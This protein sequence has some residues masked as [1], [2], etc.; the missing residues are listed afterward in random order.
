MPNRIIREALLT[1]PRVAKLKFDNRWLY[2]GLLLSADDHGRIEYTSDKLLN[3]KIFPLDDVRDSD[4]SRWLAECEKAGL[5]LIYSSN[6]SRYIQLYNFK[7][8]VRS[9]SKYPA[10]PEDGGKKEEGRR[11]TDMCQADVRQTS[12]KCTANAMQMRSTCIADDKQMP[13]KRIANAHLGEGVAGAEGERKEAY[14]SPKEKLKTKES[15]SP[16]PAVKPP[17]A[18]VKPAAEAEPAKSFIN[19]FGKKRTDPGFV[20]QRRDFAEASGKLYRVWVAS[21]KTT[22]DYNRLTQS[23]LPELTPDD[24]YCLETAGVEMTRTL[25]WYYRRAKALI[26]EQRFAEVCHNVKVL[27]LEGKKPKKNETARFLCYLE[28]EV[29]KC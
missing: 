18:F 16:R 22:A 12:D 8:Q 11:K 27:A 4:I 3:A 9:E 13:D 6:S 1:S 20:R 17:S 23:S 19:S 5:L 2:I 15:G 25:H 29:G 26:G 24:E 28:K 7:Q 10:P 14:A 21:G